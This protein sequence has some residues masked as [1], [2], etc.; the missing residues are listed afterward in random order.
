MSTV[1]FVSQKI[2]LPVKVI[3][4]LIM[5]P[6]FI[7]IP[8]SLFKTDVF[9]FSLDLA[10]LIG[11]LFT[12]FNEKVNGKIFG[13]KA[14]IMIFILFYGLS[15]FGRL[16]LDLL[17]F[18]IQMILV[19]RNLLFGIGVF[20]VA[21]AW[22]DRQSRIDH[23][24]KIFVWGGLLTSIYGIRQLLFG[25]MQFELD[26]LALMGSSL[27]EMNLLNRIR[28][29]SSFGDPLLF[30]FYMMICIFF[31]FLARKKG[32]ASFVTKKLHPWSLILI[33]LG[34]LFSLTR[35][36]LLGLFCGIFII[37]LIGF[38]LRKRSFVL[39]LKVLF[40]SILLVGGINYLVVS[41]VLAS[42]DSSLFQSINNGV[43]S[44]W[45]LTQL[46]FGDQEDDLNYFLINQSKDSRFN[47]WGLGVSYLLSNPFGA[48]LTNLTVFTFSIG[49][50][51][52]LSLGLQIGI[53]GFLFMIL[54]IFLVGIYSWSDIKSIRNSNFRSEGYFFL[55]MW[56]AI[57]ITGTISSI[58]DSSVI[59]IVVWTIAAILLNQRRIYKN[60]N[61]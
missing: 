43:E 23:I 60:H 4:F 57:I 39:V 10:L 30:G 25:F 17:F 52:I 50:T 1:D 59:S 45:S 54:I 55:G 44:V 40:G 46:V 14:V 29:T 24:T 32:I 5:V 47:S 56:F 15:V 13:G 31:Y 53:L 11:L 27:Q 20:V 6:F 26:R 41:E 22:I 51:G 19:V 16:I 2:P 48:G 12:V 9:L 35:A 34:L 8:I 28:I 42:S 3:Y 7:Y 61:S 33:F 49:D 58:L 38:R 37:L 18:N 36:P 21:S